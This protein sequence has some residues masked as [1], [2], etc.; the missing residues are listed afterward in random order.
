MATTNTTRGALTLAKTKKIEKTHYQHREI[1]ELFNPCSEVLV[2]TV[3]NEQWSNKQEVLDL[4]KSGDQNRKWKREK[5]APGIVDAAPYL[6]VTRKLSQGAGL[7]KSLR[8]PRMKN[9]ELN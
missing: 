6:R 7:N 4:E 2:V 9:M 5:K 8:C 3:V 1:Q